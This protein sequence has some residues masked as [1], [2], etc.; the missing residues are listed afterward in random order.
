[1][2]AEGKEIKQ[3][4]KESKRKKVLWTFRKKLDQRLKI[5]I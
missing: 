3:D 4:R 5:G 2:E 1:M